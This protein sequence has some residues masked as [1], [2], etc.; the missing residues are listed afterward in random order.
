VNKRP[1]A[2]LIGLTAVA[3]LIAA[4]S[5]ASNGSGVAQAPA[6]SV[7]ATKQP[8]TTTS[9][10]S[11][12]PT[13]SPTPR[14][15]GPAGY[16]TPK[17]LKPGEKPPQFVVL[18]FDGVGWHEKWAFW[19]SIAKR[20]PLRFTGFLT[21]LYLLDE[22]SRNYY[23]GP[24]HAVGT[25]S[26]G[27]WNSPA[28]VVQ[29]IKDLNQAYAN[30]DEIGTHFMGHF[31]SDNPPGGNVWTTADWDSDLDQFFH[32]FRD[33]T[34]MDKIPGMPGLKVPASSIR[35]ERTPCLEGNTAQLFPALRAHHMVFD[36][37][38]DRAG[39][40]WPQKKD[41]I[42]QMGMADF[43]LAGTNHKVITMDYN[44]WYAQEGASSNV[45]KAKSKQDTKQITHTYLNMYDAAYHG[46][47]APLI[48]GNHFEEWNN[49]AYTQALANFALKVC[50][51]PDTQCVPFID[52]VRWMDAQDPA[53]LAQLQALPPETGPRH[54]N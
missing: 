51:R 18:S 13:P 14:P 7:A 48:L 15:A 45:S 26:L 20:V 36:S 1:A 47:R 34:S 52:V 28:D 16:F 30:G 5:A 42:W 4:C 3:L 2:T 19:Q 24:G 46:N 49:N 50:A 32:V 44:F 9:K 23:H 27:A 22:R 54:G 40:A 39:I 43:P 6:V 37:S 10:P 53:T 25:S 29:E 8:R 41:G 38:P 11:T 31:C 35:G 21:G 33:H 12:K 17:K